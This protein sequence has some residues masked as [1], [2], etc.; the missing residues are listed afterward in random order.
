[1][2]DDDG[3]ASE[4]S[5]GTS[6]QA[7]SRHTGSKIENF[8]SLEQAEEF[9]RQESRSVLRAKLFLLAVYLLTALGLALAAYYVLSNAQ[10][11]TFV[12]NVSV[13]V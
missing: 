9:T 4:S 7:T 11:S 1:M 3:N 5:D 12:N 8:D 2:K 13:A 6:S 10:K